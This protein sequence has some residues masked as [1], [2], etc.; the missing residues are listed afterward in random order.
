VIRV[1]NLRN[2]KLNEGEVLVK[3]DRS[4]ALGNPFYMSNES[5]RDLVCDKYETYFDTITSNYLNSASKISD[6]DMRFMKEIARIMHIAKTKDV[7]LACWCFPKR[8]HG[9]TIMNFIN[10]YL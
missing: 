7:A 3:I 2:Y 6:K 10:K 1:I 9:I 5:Q 4:S 8:C